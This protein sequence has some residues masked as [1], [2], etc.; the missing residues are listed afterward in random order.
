MNEITRR[1][2]SY[3]LKGRKKTATTKKKISQALRNQRKTDKHK[4]A[5][6]EAMRAKWQ[7]RKI[8]LLKTYNN[9]RL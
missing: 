2:I 8:I 4:E 7:E 1:K 3:A 9:E 5:I 6:A